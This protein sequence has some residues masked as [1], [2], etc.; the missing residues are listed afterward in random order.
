MVNLLHGK[1]RNAEIF[2]IVS[3]TICILLALIMYAN[4]FPDLNQAVKNIT[5]SFRG[6]SSSEGGLWTAFLLSMF[7]NTSVFIV[8]PYAY[9]V[10]EIAVNAGTLPAPPLGAMYPIVL[11]IISGLGAG[12]GEVTSYIAGRLFARSKKLVDS[13][14]G[15]KFDSMRQTFE[16][17]PKTIPFIVFLFAVTPL[18][19]DVILVPFGVMK[20]S[21]W[22]TIIPCMLGKMVMC[23][24][25]T[26]LGFFLGNTYDLAHIPIIGLII[27]KDPS[28]PGY[29]PGD[30]MLTLLPLFIVV[31]LMIRLDFSKL[32]DRKK[33][34]TAPPA[35]EVKPVA[36]ESPQGSTPAKPSSEVELKPPAS[37]PEGT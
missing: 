5:V 29:N 1:I 25:L 9:V 3:C 32:L 4:I 8:I 27:P 33:K 10:F 37:K 11:G 13:E 14:L 18:P 7:G 19:D 35:T 23:T 20:Y 15:R 34:K 17:H 21:Y 6:F 22:K 31:Y 36:P 12:I 2:I 26:V 28:G 16:K 30:D 24:L